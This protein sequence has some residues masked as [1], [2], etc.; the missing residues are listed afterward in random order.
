MYINVGIRNDVRTLFFISFI[1]VTYYYTYAIMDAI[2]DAMNGWT[3]RIHCLFD[4]Q[5]LSKI[6]SIYVCSQFTGRCHYIKQQIPMGM[7]IVNINNLIIAK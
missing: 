2:R 3:C 6:L 1:N 7:I 5:V 4:V